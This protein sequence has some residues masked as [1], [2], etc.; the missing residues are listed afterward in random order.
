MSHNETRATLIELEAMRLLAHSGT[1][2]TATL[3]HG[4]PGWMVALMAPKAPTYLLRS[5]RHNSQPRY[6][7]TAEAAFRAVKSMGLAQVV[8]TLNTYTPDQGD[9]TR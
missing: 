7:K 6:F 3:A 9:L 8:V 4:G 1:Y 5:Q 2:P